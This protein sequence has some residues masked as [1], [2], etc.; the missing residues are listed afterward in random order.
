MPGLDQ[1]HVCWLNAPAEHELSNYD[2]QKIEF[3]QRVEN[4]IKLLPLKSIRK[5]TFYT[6]VTNVLCADVE[7]SRCDRNGREKDSI[8]KDLYLPLEI[9]LTKWSIMSKKNNSNDG[10]NFDENDTI[11]FSESNS[12]I[13]LINPGPPLRLCNTIAM[14]HAKKHKITFD[15]DDPENQNI[16]VE[17][18]WDKIMREINQFL[19]ADRTVFSKELKYVRQDLGSL[20]WLNL[21]VKQ[22]VNPINVYSLEDLYVVLMRKFNGSSDI[23]SQGIARFR[24]ESNIDI[25]YDLK[26]QCLYHSKKTEGEGSD[27]ETRYCAL[28]LSRCYSNIIAT[29]LYNCIEPV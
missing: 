25:H 13:W 1:K 9:A 20:K 27:S 2:D 3:R 14:V 15:Y 10:D 6:I 8:E 4:F 22:R 19:S 24:L 16:Y 5:K 28:A 21:N 12:K 7:S 23:P 26:L 18:D 17:N 11:K 29:D